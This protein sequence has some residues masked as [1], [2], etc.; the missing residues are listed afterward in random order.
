MTKGELTRVTVTRRQAHFGA[1]MSGLLQLPHKTSK[2]RWRDGE[3]VT[4]SPSSDPAASRRFCLDDIQGQVHTTQKVTI[5]LFGTVNIHSYTGVWGHCMQV[6]MLTK[7]AWGPQLPASVVP[8]ATYR[9]LYPGSSRVPICL[10]NL[11]AQPIEVPPKA[12]VVQVTPAN[13]VPLVVLPTEASGGST[14]GS[15]KGW[16]LEA[17]NFQ[18]L[19]EWPEAEHEQARELLLK[20]EHLFACS[21]L[22]IGK[23]SLI[24]HWIKLTYLTPFKEHYWCIPTHMYNNMK[25]HCQEM[26]DI[27]AIRKSYSPRMVAWGFAL[28]SGSWTTWP[29]RTPNYYPALMRPSIACR[30]YNGSPHLTWS[31]GTDRSRW[32]RRASH[33]LHSLWGHWVF[34]N[35]IEGPSDWPMLQWPSSG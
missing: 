24:K 6:H 2:G 22:D 35:A 4:P 1:V 9:E 20:W 15:Q 26:L 19:E 28:T 27:G 14:H 34:T 7:A 31:L 33:W 5:P 11:S 8:I 32:I 10:R 17:L 25:A 13:Q 18:G 3:Q 16:I 30:A 23:T 12:I 21:D 29:S